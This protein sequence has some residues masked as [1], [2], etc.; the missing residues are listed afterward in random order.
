LLVATLL[1]TG[2]IIVGSPAGA[3]TLGYPNASATAHR[4]GAPYY[5]WWVDENGDGRKDVPEELISGRGYGYRTD[6]DFVAWWLQT[7]GVPDSR[8]RDLHNGGEWATYAALRSGIAVRDTPVRYGVAVQ[9]GN[10]GHVAFIDDVLSDGRITVREYNAGGTGAGGTWTG[11][12]ASRGFTK[13]LDFGLST[14]RLP[15]SPLAMARNA[16]GR[17]EVFGIATDGAPAHKWQLSAGGAWSSW[18]RF[19]GDLTDI[20]AETN[21]DGRIELFGLDPNGAISHKWQQIRDGSWSRWTPIEGRLTSIAIARNYDGRMEVFGANSSQVMYHKSQLIAGGRWSRWSRFAG[22]LTD[23][24]AETNA[25]G[26]IELFGLDPNGAITHTWQ[27]SPGGSWSPW[28]P[29]SG[30]LTSIAIARNYDGRL[31]VFGTNSAQAIYHRSQLNAGGPWSSWSRFSGRLTHVAAETNADGR[32]EVFG[33]ASNGAIFHNW[34]YRPGGS[35]W[36]WTRV[37]GGLRP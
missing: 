26:R 32:I 25:D 17:L 23:V 4:P 7:L 2:V 9:V 10:P 27:Q 22:S 3:E 21:A 28:T 12:P 20:A 35:W 19:A 24:A 11:S 1:V 30:R 37:E 14:D 29:M 36:S 5:E 33:V 34:Q 31:E 8:T 18:S 6:T 13:F 16:D 15:G